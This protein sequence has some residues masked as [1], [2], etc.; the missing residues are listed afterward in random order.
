MNE[1]MNFFWSLVCILVKLMSTNF[2]SRCLLCLCYDMV[3]NFWTWY[4]RSVRSCEWMNFVFNESIVLIWSST[5]SLSRRDPCMFPFT[6]QHEE[7]LAYSQRRSQDDCLGGGRR[8]STPRVP[9]EVRGRGGLNRRDQTASVVGQVWYK[10]SGSVGP[11]MYK[12]P[13]F[14]VY[15]G[16]FFFSH[17]VIRSYR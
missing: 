13:S 17:I 12:D 4:C 16:N 14:T 10:L 6:G 1:W 9:G 3:K 15:R 5:K 11:L 8:R 7:I 2:M